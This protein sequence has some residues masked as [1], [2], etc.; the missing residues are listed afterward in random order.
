VRESGRGVSGALIGLLLAPLPR[1]DPPC[2]PQEIS[3][4]ERGGG[5]RKAISS[6]H[7]KQMPGRRTGAR[8][9][10]SSG[11]VFPEFQYSH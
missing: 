3:N 4:F 11:S 1:S 7:K 9:T 8:K 6:A 2:L 10:E 5:E